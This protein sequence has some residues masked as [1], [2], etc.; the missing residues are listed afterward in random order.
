MGRFHS[1]HVPKSEG[2]RALLRRYADT[3]PAAQVQDDGA[4]RHAHSALEEHVARVGAQARVVVVFDAL[5]VLRSLGNARRHGP[6]PPQWGT[7][8]SLQQEL[9]LER[10]QQER[11]LYAPKR[12]AGAS[13]AD[14]L[15]WREWFA[16]FHQVCERALRRT[17]GV[18]SLVLCFDKH[19]HVPLAKSVVHVGRDSAK[20]HPDDL[21]PLHIALDE[22]T[23][24]PAHLEAYLHDRQ[25]SRRYVLQCLCRTLLLSDEPELSLRAALAPGQRVFVDGHC[26]SAV[27][28]AVLCTGAP[29]PGHQAEEGEL[30]EEELEALMLDDAEIPRDPRD[31]SDSEDSQ[32]DGSEADDP[33][34]DD[35]ELDD[36]HGAE[37]VEISDSEDERPRRAAAPA[38]LA[39]SRDS[40]TEAAAEPAYEPASESES[41]SEPEPEPPSQRVGAEVHTHDPQLAADD[42]RR[43]DETPLELAHGQA[44]CR[45]RPEFRNECGEADFGVYWWARALD[46]DDWRQA[47]TPTTPQHLVVYGTDTD[48]MF[49]GLLYVWRCRY[50]YGHRVLPQVYQHKRH[51]RT[52]GSLINEHH[53]LNELLRAVQ[54]DPALR[55]VLPTAARVPALCAAMASAGSDYTERH[56]G[57]DHECFLKAFF[58]HAPAA[59]LLRLDA[60]HAPLLDDAGR[61]REA[62]AALGADGWPRERVV[63]QRRSRD[64]HLDP[65]GYEQLVFGAHML[66]TVAKRQTRLRQ[67]AKQ[68]DKNAV[69]A[70]A[71]LRAQAER[72]AEAALGRG[73]ITRQPLAA[74]LDRRRAPPSDRDLVLSGMQLLYYVRMMLCV[75]DRQLE[76]P[77]L[78]GAYGYALHDPRR[79]PVYKNVYRPIDGLAAGGEGEGEGEEPQ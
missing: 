73:T 13:A 25:Y 51:T 3:H 78:C 43:P 32:F 15:T 44:R 12:G 65:A 14:T 8:L 37:V 61:A 33:A 53:H 67:Q 50:V 7:A 10:Q 26:L 16:R 68:A 74:L 45:R 46:L 42:P 22:P 9:E 71:V 29:P 34:L 47:E 79:G 59:S 62:A 27:D 39:E 23:P 57:V 64:V 76:A 17:P 11:E 20:V 77:D 4:R 49:L 63:Q 31:D 24:P 1:E 58:A 19:E 70:A 55:D 18:R 72:E 28:T 21:P 2:R 35:L 41:E 56:W 54:H 5:Y 52:N 6:P 75:G 40:E 38:D 48:L 36:D 69:P 60:P 66:R 30:N